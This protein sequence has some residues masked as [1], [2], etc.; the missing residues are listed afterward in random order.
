M[1]EFSTF[2]F[3]RPS[4]MEG[5]ARVFDLGGTLQ[6]YN[7][8]A[9]PEQADELAQEMDIRAVNAD[10]RAALGALAN[11]SEIVHSGE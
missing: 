4:S 3:A 1:G 2:L 5:M 8:S 6:E 7:V 11:S 9:S 10:F